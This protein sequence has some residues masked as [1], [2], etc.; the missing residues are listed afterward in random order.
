MHSTD[1]EALPEHALRAVI[2]DTLPDMMHETYNIVM[3]VLRLAK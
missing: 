1:R 3:D 2:S